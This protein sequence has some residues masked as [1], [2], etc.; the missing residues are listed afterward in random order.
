MG[1]RSVWDEHQDWDGVGIRSGIGWAPG[2]YRMSTG[3]YG[4]GIR[5][6]I[7]WAPGLYGISTGTGMG[8]VL[9]LV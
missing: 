9:G 3:T 2:L 5:S 8:W 7:G 6:G 1:T 4:M